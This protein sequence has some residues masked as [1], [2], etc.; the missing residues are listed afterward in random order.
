MLAQVAHRHSSG[1]GD[2][3]IQGYKDTNGRAKKRS[4][5]FAYFVCRWLIYMKASHPPPVNYGAVH[6]WSLS[7]IKPAQDLYTRQERIL[8]RGG[9]FMHKEKHLQMGILI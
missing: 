6:V 9:C 3:G 8:P 4:P 1:N 5:D 7:Q 2:T